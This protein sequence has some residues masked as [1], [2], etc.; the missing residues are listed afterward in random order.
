MAGVTKMETEFTKQSILSSGVLTVVIAFVS[1]YVGL[2]ILTFG[3]SIILGVLV[4]LMFLKVGIAGFILIVILVL[5]GVNLSKHAML[6]ISVITNSLSEFA[7]SA[8]RNSGKLNKI[9]DTVIISHHEVNNSLFEF[10]DFIWVMMVSS[11]LLI[12]FFWLLKRNNQ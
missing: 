3:V 6:A 8:I 1:T 11:V 12:T 7:Q 10:S 4:S 5:L 9:G 2:L